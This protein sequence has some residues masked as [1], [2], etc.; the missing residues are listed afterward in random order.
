MGLQ[1]R[2]RHRWKSLQCIRHATATS[3][4][5][6]VQSSGRGPPDTAEKEVGC[7]ERANNVQAEL[8]GFE[9]VAAAVQAPAVQPAAASNR[10]GMLY[11]CI[12][13]KVG[14]IIRKSCPQA[15]TA[16]RNGTVSQSH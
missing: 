5:T 10:A 8:G 12:L 4:E 11:T 2:L 6:N 1:L 14:G 3:S 7:P 16:V 15:G 9:A 13:L